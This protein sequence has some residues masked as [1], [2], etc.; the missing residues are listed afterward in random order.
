MTLNGVKS[1]ARSREWRL[2]GATSFLVECKTRA[3]SFAGLFAG[4]SNLSP[5]GLISHAKSR[6]ILRA[7]L[8]PVIEPRGRN[9]RVAEP[10]LD[11]GDVS[12]VGERVSGGGR[13]QR[14]HA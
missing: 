14:M 11:R 3:N 7:R 8:A 4:R 5:V 9:I 6:T 2:A 13:V 12:L 10:L 1:S